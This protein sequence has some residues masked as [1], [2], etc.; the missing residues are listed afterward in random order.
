MLY[1]SQAHLMLAVLLE[2]TDE[3][4]REPPRTL[5]F[6]DDTVICRGAGAVKI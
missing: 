5:M 1:F 3:A 2:V 6:A 4:R